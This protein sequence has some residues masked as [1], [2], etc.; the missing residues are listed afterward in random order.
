MLTLT[1]L[2]IFSAVRVY[3]A[4]RA[5]DAPH[6]SLS[7]Y[8]LSHSLSLSHSCVGDDGCPSD[9]QESHQQRLASCLRSRASELCPV[10]PCTQVGGVGGISLVFRRGS[11]EGQRDDMDGPI[12]RLV[13]INPRFHLKHVSGGRLPTVAAE[14]EGQRGTEPPGARRTGIRNTSHSAPSSWRV[15]VVSAVTPLLAVGV[16]VHP[17]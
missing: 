10:G 6:L 16:N 11:V 4:V 3:A 13:H 5:R 9:K 8:A 15:G 2:L 17:S 1:Y 12:V 7:L 14:G